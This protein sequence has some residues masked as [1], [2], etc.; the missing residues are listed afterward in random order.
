MGSTLERLDED[1]VKVV[2]SASGL[3]VQL[4]CMSALGCS[5]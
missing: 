5:E 2:L 3:S 4:A 1:G